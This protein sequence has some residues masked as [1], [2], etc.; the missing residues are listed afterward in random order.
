MMNY[1]DGRYDACYAYSTD[2]G[3][4]WFRHERV[5]DDTT[6]DE[7]YPDIAADSAG[8]AYL[9]WEDGRQ[10]SPGIWFSTNNW[11]P[12]AEHPAQPSGFQPLA[13][14][15][16]GVLLLPRPVPATFSL[17]TSTGRKAL[18]LRSGANDVSRLTPGVYF[19]RD[20]QARTQDV[21]KVVVTR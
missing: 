16:R 6:G 15:V 13:S 17:L 12:N 11:S 10:S 18:E 4:T 19:V 5:N 7:F 21:S 3:V 9:V 1:R 14:V 2:H 20:A 8:H